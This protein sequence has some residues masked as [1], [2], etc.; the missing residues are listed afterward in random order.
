[1]GRQE[2]TANRRGRRSQAEILDVASRIMSER[3][4][5]ATSISDICRESGLPNS[6][7]YHHYGSKAGLLSAV[8]E[9]GAREF[10][11][12]LE[13][14]QTNPPTGGSTQDRLTWFLC[15]TGDVLGSHQ[16]FLRLFM[17]LLLSNEA[18]EA[19]DVV[20]RVRV[21]GNQRMHRMLKASFADHGPQ[22][23]QVVADQLLDFAMA[24]FEGAFLGLQVQAKTPHSEL[25]NQL[26]EALSDLGAARLAA[27]TDRGLPLPGRRDG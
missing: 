3:G 13:E 14:R 20:A 24:G 6:V 26:A 17:I 25:M 11:Q 21:E 7:I 18:P 27:M 23:A 10:F 12:A 5:A 8:M 9:R 16:E 15:T 22:A 2:T 19:A 4:Y 1:M